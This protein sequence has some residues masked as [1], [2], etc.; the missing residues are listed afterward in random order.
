M[1]NIT[2][3]NGIIALLG[4]LLY[5]LHKYSKRPKKHIPFSFAF[6]LKDNAIEI[7]ISAISGMAMFLALDDIVLLMQQYMPNQLPADKLVVPIDKMVA[8]LTGFL[9]ISIVRWIFRKLNL[10]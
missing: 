5:L 2:L 3:L 4:L 8:F 10:K 7:C 9:N 1:Q 6:W